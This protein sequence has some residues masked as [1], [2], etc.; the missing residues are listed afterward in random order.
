MNSSYSEKEQIAQ[1]YYD[2]IETD[3]IYAMIWGEHI[4]FGIY[5]EPNDSMSE[6]S[7]RTVETMAQ[8]LRHINHEYQVIDLGAGYGGSAR[9]LAKNWF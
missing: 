4:H 3:Q 2:N 1:N 7:Q 8:T 9:Y 6:A 5:L